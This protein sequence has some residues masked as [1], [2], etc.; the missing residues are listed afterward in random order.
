MLDHLERTRITYFWDRVRGSAQGVS[1][2][3]WQTFALLIAIRVFQA[4]DMVKAALPAAFSIGFLVTP[5]TLYLL[6]RCQ[7]RTGTICA[8]ISCCAAVCMIIV[9][10]ADRLYFFIFMVL[11][12]QILGAQIVPLVTQ[13]YTTNY[14]PRERGSRFSTILM[15]SASMGVLVSY[16]GG[17]LL[18]YDLNLYP[19]IF[20]TTAVA[21]LVAAFSFWKMPTGPLNP[22]ATGNPWENIS[23][24]WKDKLFGWMLGG[25]MLLG[26]CNLMLLPIRV[27]Y[28]ANP[29][30]GINATNEQVGI[31]LGAIP[32]AMRIVSTK[33]WG[34]FFDRV[35]FI[36]LRVVLNLIFIAS[37]LIFFNTKSL[38]LM[39]L[40]AA[41]FGIG[42][43]GGSIMWFLWVTKIAPPGK[44]P[45]YMS[46][47]SAFTGLRGI[48]APFLGYLLLRY[49]DP[50]AVAWIA[51]T[52]GFISIL[53]FIPARDRFEAIRLQELDEKTC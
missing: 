49:I 15:F 12:S 8:Y 40:G 17:R 20:L 10:N 3:C 30:Y 38:L 11:G 53:I 4:P 21:T 13:I 28:M 26:M 1:E 6:S 22:Q 18:D 33:I 7:W 48:F 31:I 35:N 14:P 45:V 27:E 41:L 43:G 2:A 23:L 5:I 50:T 42:L 25:W 52:L 34:H 32:L 47:H 39:G 36:R 19:V 9:A 16:L 24:A 51:A 44:I 29:L 46:V 37:I